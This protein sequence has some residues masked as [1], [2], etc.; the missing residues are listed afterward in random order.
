[1]GDISIDGMIILKYILRDSD[2][3]QNPMGNFCEHV[4]HTGSIKA[5]NF[6]TSPTA[7]IVSLFLN[8]NSKP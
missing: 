1:L 4:E 5:R 3:G 8:I 2:S 7:H 6:M